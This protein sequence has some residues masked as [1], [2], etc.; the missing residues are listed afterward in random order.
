MVHIRQARFLSTRQLVVAGL[1]G[2]IAIVLGASG[3]GLIPVPT[4][5]GR[6]TI[7][8][9]PVILAGVLEGPLTGGMVG[10]IFGF[11]SFTTAAVPFLLDPVIAFVPRILIGVLAAWTYRFCQTATRGLAPG[12]CPGS[13]TAASL[14]HGAGSGGRGRAF[15]VGVFP[16]LA[17]AVVGTLTNTVGV[18]GLAVWRGY[19]PWEAAVGVAFTHGLP[20]VVLAAVLIVIILRSLQRFGPYRE[21]KP[22]S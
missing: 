2:G 8:H 7:M 13:L 3:L 11:Y 17:A 4:P 20:E 14:P 10:F 5:A 12:S 15:L 21:E 18:L 19:L 1:L 6:A 22:C 9:V 16:G